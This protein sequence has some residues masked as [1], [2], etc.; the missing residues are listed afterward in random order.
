MCR[1]RAALRKSINCGYSRINVLRI[2][3]SKEEE[4]YAKRM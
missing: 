2:L 1:A 4:G 3:G